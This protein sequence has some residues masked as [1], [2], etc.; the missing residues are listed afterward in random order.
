MDNQ[1]VATLF[2]VPFFFF[3]VAMY[4]YMA[5]VLQVMAKKTG[6][7]NG[8]LA[9]IP[10]VNVFLM[11]K[12][13]GK[14]YWWF[15]LLCIPFVNLVIIIIL[16]MALAERLGHPA[17]VGVLVIVPFVNIIVPG[18]L[19]FAKPSITGSAPMN[20]PAAPSAS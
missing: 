17:W 7:P 20:P 18:Y 13:A 9:W 1:S 8:W 5:Y 19:A 2:F 16:Y 4:V 6:T 11:L 14:S 12:I 3:V 10:L 15:L